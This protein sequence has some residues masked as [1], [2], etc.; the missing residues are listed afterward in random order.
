MFLFLLVTEVINEEN[1][2]SYEDGDI[3]FKRISEVLE[4]KGQIEIDFSKIEILTS[5]FLTASIGQLYERYP[6]DFIDNNLRITKLKEEYEN[7]LSK[8]ILVSKEYINN[9]K[10]Y[11]DLIDD[12]LYGN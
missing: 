11:D 5:T 8:V 3:L 10:K 1:A 12:T 4:L 9:P 7:L 2:I 6:E